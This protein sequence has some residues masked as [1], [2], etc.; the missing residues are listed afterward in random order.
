MTPGTCSCR[1]AQLVVAKRR[2]EFPEGF[3]GRGLGATSECKLD[4]VTHLAIQPDTNDIM[5]LLSIKECSPVHH[6]WTTTTFSYGDLWDIIMSM[7]RHM[8]F[9]IAETGF[10]L[11]IPSIEVRVRRR[12][13]QSSESLSED[14]M[15]QDTWSVTRNEHGDPVN[16]RLRGGDEGLTTAE[17][18][19]CVLWLSASPR[20]VMAFLGLDYKTYSAGFT[21]PED[22]FR[23]LTDSRIFRKSIFHNPAINSLISNQGFL[24]R[25]FVN[26]W[27]PNAAE[28]D[29]YLDRRELL[30]QSLSTFRKRFEYSE[31]FSQCINRSMWQSIA[32]V[33]PENRRANGLKCLKNLLY[34]ENGGVAL[35]TRQQLKQDKSKNEMQEYIPQW[36]ALNRWIV[37]SVIVPWVSQHWQ[38]AVDQMQ[39]SL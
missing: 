37:E 21:T 28:S 31:A 6:P 9:E 11:R 35:R 10:Y 12:A 39:F 24:F 22:A 30:H 14:T 19:S 4:R 32:D 5:N 20:K 34:W 29:E 15:D 13:W 7:V 2:A 38:L 36:V 1:A 3:L 8:G 33:I 27:V 25:R 26:K 16:V 17:R 18:E 23:F